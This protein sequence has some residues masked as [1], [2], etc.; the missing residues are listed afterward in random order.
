MRTVFAISA[1]LLVSACGAKQEA[2]KAPE[3]GAPETVTV[4]ATDDKPAAFNQ[5]AVCHKVEKGGSNGVGPNLHGIVGTK[6]GAVAGYSYSDALKGWGQNWTE[7]NLDKFLANPRA[8][9][10][11]TKMAYSGM[12]DAAQRKEVIEWL[13]KQK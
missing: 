6:A 2:A 9:V 12:T 10:P 5:C 7:A 4:A 1:L 11:G 3:P 13:K 8:L